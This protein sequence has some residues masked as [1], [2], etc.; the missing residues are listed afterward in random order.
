MATTTAST[1]VVRHFVPRGSSKK[2]WNS[3][4][5]SRLLELITEY[6]ASNWSIIA[7]KLVNRTGKQCRERYHN[8]LNPDVKKGDW[9][10]IEDIIL[11][12]LHAKHGNQWAKIAKALP[13]RTDNAIKNRWHTAHRPMCEEE[14]PASGSP[15]SR[16]SQICCGDSSKVCP[17]VSKTYA[18]IVPA[19]NL[20][21][22]TSDITSGDYEY[23][24]HAHHS[25][26][27]TLSSRSDTLTEPQDIVPPSKTATTRPR[28][29]SAFDAASIFGLSARMLE[30]GLARSPC[31][32]YWINAKANCNKLSEVN[33][34][35]A[36]LSPRA[37]TDSE[38]SEDYAIELPSPY[39]FG[40]QTLR[41]DIDSLDCS[42]LSTDAES[43]FGD[44]MDLD[45][46][47]DES[48][49]IT[50]FAPSPASRPKPFGCKFPSESVTSVSLR[51]PYMPSPSV[52]MIQ[53]KRRV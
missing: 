26:E 8:H 16:G 23:H 53:K 24:D 11:A 29:N 19:L 25:H 40:H 7:E 17:S 41:L 46:D 48:S 20:R 13:G 31:L 52:S 6:G 27:A 44:D 32:Q 15:L 3:A 2:S 37:E 1:E 50:Q 33:Y 30:N 4:E 39:N 18:A 35:E 10:E 47:S 9:T 36:F 12:D 45:L 21:E 42:P 43:F 22:A 14:R 51:S 34:S 49:H 5:D 38:S 28:Q